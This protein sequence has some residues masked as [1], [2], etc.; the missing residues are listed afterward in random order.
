MLEPNNFECFAPNFPGFWNI[1]SKMQLKTT[2]CKKN[3]DYLGSSCI[4]VAKIDYTILTYN[5]D[6]GGTSFVTKHFTYPDL[7]KAKV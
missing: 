4:Y 6:W 1:P 7:T 5:L 2:I 3:T